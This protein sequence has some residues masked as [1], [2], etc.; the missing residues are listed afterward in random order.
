MQS[1]LV[2]SSQK[3]HI[4][5]VGQPCV[6]IWERLPVVNGTHQ[7]SLCSYLLLCLEVSFVKFF[8]RLWFK[9]SQLSSWWICK[10]YIT[11]YSPKSDRRQYLELILIWAQL[12]KSD[13]RQYLELIL[14]WA[15]LPKSDRRQ[16]LELILIWAQ[17]P[18][19]CKFWHGH[20]KGKH[21]IW[22]P[23][24]TKTGCTAYD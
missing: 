5:N 16:Y 15:Q 19:Q 24:C 20:K 3:K 7:F 10:L 22:K 21:D 1:F 9:M 11:G 13:R 17:L 14:I 23:R 8:G 2:S 4:G 12:P 6:L 18:L